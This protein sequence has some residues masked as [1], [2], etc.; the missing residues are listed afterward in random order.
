MMMMMCLIF[1][2]SL[3]VAAYADDAQRRPDATIRPNAATVL[4]TNRILALLEDD[5]A[6]ILIRGLVPELWYAVSGWRH[7]LC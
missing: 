6:G 7:S 2:T 3:A 1:D 5:L 4:Q